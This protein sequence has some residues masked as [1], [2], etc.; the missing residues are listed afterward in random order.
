MSK[1][2]VP[3]KPGK[4]LASAIKDCLKRQMSDL[5]TGC[6][7]S[8]VLSWQKSQS[9]FLR[10]S[11]SIDGI[12]FRLAKFHRCDHRSDPAPFQHTG[13]L[14]PDLLAP[15]GSTTAVVNEIESFR[16]SVCQRQANHL[17]DKC[18]TELAEAGAIGV[19]DELP[20]GALKVH[21]I[22]DGSRITTDAL[23]HQKSGQSLRRNSFEKQ[24][25][26]LVGKD[27]A[28]L[29]RV[30]C[31][32]AM[33][34]TDEKGQFLSAPH[35]FLIARLGPFVL[36]TSPRIVPR[37]PLLNLSNRSSFILPSLHSK[38]EFARAI[39]GFSFVVAPFVLLVIG[40]LLDSP[41]GTSLLMLG[42]LLLIA[43]CFTS[44]ATTS[45]ITV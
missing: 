4:A 43:G 12:V 34:T 36:Q 16:D 26:A 17:V 35:E 21:Q 30:D 28:G 11:Q 14:R 1:L 44:L 45:S 38:A 19:A 23:V 27:L 13:T 22:S 32:I 7:A 15:D 39:A 33:Q 18:L 29:V 6:Q 3:L 20:N 42:S 31:V 2:T 41:M 9:E 24:T 5:D 8:V 10:S 37:P 40:L 25:V